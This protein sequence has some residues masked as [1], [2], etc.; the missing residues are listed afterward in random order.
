MDDVIVDFSSRD[1]AWLSIG[2]VIMGGISSGRMTV[3]DGVATFAGEVSFD[4]NGGFASVRSE[5]LELDLSAWDGVVL[6]V[7]GDGKRYGF[8]IRT[9]ASFDGVSYQAEVAPPPGEWIE[10]ALPFRD[11]APVHRGRSVPEHPPLDPA[12]VTTFG[13]MISRQEGPF[14]LELAGIR[15]FSRR[16]S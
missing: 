12:H 10:V 8:R 1:D 13:L 5:P 4:N 9:T 14:R 2:D 3:A 15:G 6:R 16:A 11:F 7:R